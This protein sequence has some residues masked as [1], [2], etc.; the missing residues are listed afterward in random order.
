ME[1]RFNGKK[2]IKFGEWIWND[3]K[4]P[5][6]YKK[7]IFDRFMLEHAQN[8]RHQHYENLK[9]EVLTM[10]SSGISAYMIA[11]LLGLNV[12]TVYAWRKKI[13]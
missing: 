6:Y 12:G 8:I 2:A 10:L 4:L 13:C 3:K 1:I 5:E 7:E 9:S 11:K